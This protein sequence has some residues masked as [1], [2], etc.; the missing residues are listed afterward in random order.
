[1][2]ILKSPNELNTADRKF[3]M[4]RGLLGLL[5]CLGLLY[6]VG[7]SSLWHGLDVGFATLPL[8][9]V[10]PGAVLPR[11]IAALLL[12]TL[13]GLAR[14]RRASGLKTLVCPNCNRLKTN[15]GV[16]RCDCGGTFRGIHEM[17]WVEGSA[18]ESGQPT[19]KES[20]PN[21]DLAALP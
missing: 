6:L 13:Y 5:C 7:T 1:M 17:K 4:L 12:G 18:S 16:S 19:A 20:A 9:S 14:K 21:R 15:D 3:R 10:I 11:V 2:W 8:K